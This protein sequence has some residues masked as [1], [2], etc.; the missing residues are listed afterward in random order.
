MGDERFAIERGN[1]GLNRGDSLSPPLYP[2][3][4]GNIFYFDK[5]DV[6]GVWM[7]WHTPVTIDQYTSTCACCF[8]LERG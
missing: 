3:Q 5:G 4:E 2:A 8:H 7:T 6:S 1:D